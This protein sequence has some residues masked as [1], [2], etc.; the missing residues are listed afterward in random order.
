MERRGARIL[1]A[2]TGKIGPLARD[3][4]ATINATEPEREA[5]SAG[6]RPFAI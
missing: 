2:R 5:A 1:G 3:R 4:P 6:A